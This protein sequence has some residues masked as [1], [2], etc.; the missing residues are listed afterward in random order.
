MLE[1]AVA[2]KKGYTLVELRERMTEE[3]L[4]LWQAFYNVQGQ[5]QAELRQKH[6]ARRR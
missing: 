4:L 6:A 5:M 2:D 1:M 3:E